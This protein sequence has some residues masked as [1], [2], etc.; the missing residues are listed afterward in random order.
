MLSREAATNTNFILTIITPI[1]TIVV[2]RSINKM[3]W[4]NISAY[5]DSS[6][7]R[8]NSYASLINILEGTHPRTHKYYTQ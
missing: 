8:V 3:T 4:Y 2:S 7:T 6:P 5:S 1:A